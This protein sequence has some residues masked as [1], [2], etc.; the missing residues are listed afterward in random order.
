MRKR[1]GQPVPGQPI[2]LM[3]AQVNASEFTW[4]ITGADGT[5]VVEH[6]P[7]GTAPGDAHGLAGPGQYTNGMSRDVEVREGETVTVDF[8]SRD[9]L[10]SGTG[11][12]LRRSGRGGGDEPS[13]RADADV[14][15]V[16]GPGQLERG[17]PTGPQRN[18]ADHSR[19]R[20]VR[21]SW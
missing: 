3:G 15:D 2:W 10:V 6:V 21:S 19:R 14:H 17:A 16:R 11:H 13:R 20:V 7:A 5:F 8:V 1:D 4:P 12:A 9:V 18:R